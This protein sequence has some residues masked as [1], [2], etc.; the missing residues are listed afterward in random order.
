MDT[1]EEFNMARTFEEKRLY[2]AMKKYDE[3]RDYLDSNPYG[4]DM[5]DKISEM[6]YYEDLIAK[7][8]V[9]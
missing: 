6:N 9:K 1:Q 4:Y 8:L 3:I 5:K 2:V 7:I